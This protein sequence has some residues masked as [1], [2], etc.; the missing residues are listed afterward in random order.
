MLKGT[1]NVQEQV[2]FGGLAAILAGKYARAQSPAVSGDRIDQLE[3]Q[4]QALERYSS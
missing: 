3:G 2:W 1:N 4:I